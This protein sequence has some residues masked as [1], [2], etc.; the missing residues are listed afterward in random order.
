MVI[1]L[2]DLYIEWGIENKHFD[3]NKWQ[4]HQGCPFV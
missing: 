1:D 2:N 3:E 4:K